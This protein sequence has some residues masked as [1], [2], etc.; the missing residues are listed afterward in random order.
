M[1]NRE[2]RI[3]KVI[4]IGTRG[5]LF[6][7]RELEGME[8]NVY[9]INGPKHVFVIDTFLGP[10]SM[11]AV[12]KLM[13]RAL[14]KK[15]VV[16]VNSHYHWDHIWGNCAFPGRL[17]VAHAL[18]REKIARIGEKELKAYSAMRQGNVKLILPNCTFTDKMSFA[19]DGIEFFH[20]PGH[21][22]D[23]ISIYDKK[24]E[25]LF[26]GDN[27]E[28]PLPYLY[29]MD[30]GQYEKTLQ[31]CLKIK[32]KRVIA[33][34]CAHVTNDI[35][36]KNLEYIRAFRTGKTKKY[37]KGQ[38]RQTHEQNLKVMQMFGNK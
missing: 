22:D 37:E 16:I 25:V 36:A 32:A 20:S 4:K 2:L 35:I 21:S 27:V 13:G 7:F 30:L 14:R 19:D 9:V 29:S 8:A 5:M 3:T 12:K 34:H 38:Y 17:I 6:I 18:C 10:K 26:V 33:G 28:K 23:S 1:V 24:D 31:S 11:D 15:P